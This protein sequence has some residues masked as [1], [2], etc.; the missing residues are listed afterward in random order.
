MRT[1]FDQQRHEIP[2]RLTV[3][4]LVGVIDGRGDGHRVEIIVSF[5]EFVY[6]LSDLLAFFIDGVHAK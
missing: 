2:N 6:D 3:E 4:S 5:G 1:T